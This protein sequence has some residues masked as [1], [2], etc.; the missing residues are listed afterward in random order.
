MMTTAPGPENA[1]PQAGP[2]AGDPGQT[3]GRTPGQMADPAAGR[4]WW[5]GMLVAGLALVLDQAS[6]WW[7]LTV[8][9]P[10]LSGPQGPG[11]A[12]PSP[13]I[14]VTDFFNIVMA[15]N[16]GVSFGLFAHEAEI[17]PVLLIALALAISA[18]LMLWLWRS[19]RA[20]EAVALGMVIGGAIG[21]VVDRVRFGAVADFLDLHVA[22]W[23]W[24][25]FNVADSGIVLGVGL[26]LLDG[27]RAGR[28]GR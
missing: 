21:N 18:V 23:H 20:L 6:K 7:I 9:Q 28:A 11:C 2:P 1:A 4:L 25:A 14:I 8:V 10:C 13:F 26:L 22:G 12:V 17:M 3:P 19:T 24:P 5:V 16:R 27:W 15:W